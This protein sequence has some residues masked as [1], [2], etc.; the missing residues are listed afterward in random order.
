MG[1]Q[2][3]AAE[4]DPEGV[5]GTWGTWSFLEGDL[6]SVSPCP[7][8]RASCAMDDGICDEFSFLQ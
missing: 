8:Q 4:G 3:S 2:L 6:D 1:K 5:W 7:P